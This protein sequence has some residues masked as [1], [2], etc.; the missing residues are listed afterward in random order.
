VITPDGAR[1]RVRTTYG[2]EHDLGLDDPSPLAGA[3]RRHVAVRAW[4]P[5]SLAVPARIAGRTFG[6]LEFRF[7]DEEPMDEDMAAVAR[8]LAE[9]MAS[10]VHRA[11]LYEEERDAAHQLQQA[12]LPVVPDVLPG[13]RFA[14]CYRAADEDHDIGGDWY[15]AFPL[16]GDR[17]GFAVGDVV[18]HD[19]RA[20]AAMGRLH[21]ALRVLAYELDEGPAAVLE[22]LDRASS[23]IPGAMMATIGYGEYDPRSGLLCYACAGHPPPLLV[24]DHHVRYLTG[25]RSRP[26]VMETRPRPEA[27][28]DVPAGSML[29]WYSDGLLERRHEDLDAG[30]DR[31]VSVTSRLDGDDP[32]VWRDTVMHELTAGQL[33]Q[34]DVVV[35]CLLLQRST[36][37]PPLVGMDPG[38]APGAS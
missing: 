34:D 2:Q 3:A 35:I 11:R 22:A 4:S 27:R 25:G 31:L 6:A 10:A 17:V 20:A 19:L 16:P 30:L 5:T 36:S 26:V 23:D 12:F 1:L 37:P 15:D 38:R 18:G 24:T 21:T 28:V 32:Q 14:G 29:L 8:T 33:L 9:L 13:A 7:S